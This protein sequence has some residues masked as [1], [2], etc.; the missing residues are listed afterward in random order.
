MITDVQFVIRRV[1]LLTVIWYWLDHFPKIEQEKR[2]FIIARKTIWDVNVIIWYV[3]QKVF[4]NP[5]KY[6]VLNLAK[7]VLF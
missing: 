3:L 1:D 7:I 6:V 5:A 4:F 2:I